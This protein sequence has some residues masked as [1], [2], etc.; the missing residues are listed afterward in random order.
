MTENFLEELRKINSFDAA[1]ISSVTLIKAENKVEVSIITDKAYVAD[2]VTA[3]KKVVRKFVPEMFKS[4]LNVTK[5]TPDEDMVAKKI[6]EII[7]ET[8]KQL[9]AFVTSDDIKVHKTEDGF[10]FTVAVVHASNYTSNIAATIS[11]K[12]KK[13]FCGQFSG[14]CVEVESK[15]DD[16]VIEDK[17]ENIQYEIA[18]RSFEIADFSFLEGG[19]EHKHAIYIADLNFVS[20]SVVICGEITNIREKTITNSSG[21]EKVMYNFTVNDTT[22]SIRV[23]YFTRQK[24]IEKI[25]KLKVGD[26]IVMTCKTDIF[27]G[28][29]RPTANFI[30]YGSIP[31]GFVPE[32]RASKPVPKYYETVFPEPYIDYTQSNLFVDG[33]LPACLTDNVFVV[34]DLETTG[35]NS[36]PSTGNMDRIIEIGAYKIIGGEIKEC[37]NTFVNPERKLSAEI[38]NLTGIEQPTV[39]A[40][41][42]FDKVM[43]DFFKFIDGCYLVG[44]NAANFDYKFIDYY[45]S[46]CGYMPE[47]RIFDTLFLSQSVLR[48]SNY[49]LNTVADYFGITF[50][51]HRAADDALVT[52]KIFIELLKIKKSLPTPC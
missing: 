5:L 51:H 25:K 9:A 48:L 20:E 6:F 52:A 49:K 28:E 14:K 3:A 2:D 45:C 12:L 29:I 44:H 31:A 30:D 18:P 37:F 7:G 23:G 39:D 21:R 13:C 42:T 47:R 16:I 38:V 17:P 46:Q 27:N 8:N 33:N 50:N 34:F 19:V 35:L 10:Y 4:A 26:S 22:A 1:I 32:K 11:E 41:P 24:S 43:P 40:A 15:L 36:S